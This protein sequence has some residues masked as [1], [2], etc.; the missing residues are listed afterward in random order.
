MLIY[1]ISSTHDI[2]ASKAAQLRFYETLRTELGS[3]V[4][5]TI[6]TAGYVESEI[7][8]GKGVQKG[9]EVAVDEDARDVSCLLLAPPP[10]SLHAVHH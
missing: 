10:D 5:I 8:K 4:G 3:E 6:L 1:I 9:G 2:Q 7:T